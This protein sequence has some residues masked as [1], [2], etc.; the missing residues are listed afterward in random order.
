MGSGQDWSW[1]VWR[2]D[3]ALE[4]VDFNGAPVLSATDFQAISSGSMPFMLT[5]NGEAA[6]VIDRSGVRRLVSGQAILDVRMGG[7]I[8][9]TWDGTF[10]MGNTSGDSLNF[11]AAGTML[12][13]GRLIGNQTAYRLVVGGTAFERHT[14]TDERII[15]SLLGPAGATRPTGVIGTFQFT[16]RT[17]VTVNGGFGA[18]LVDSGG[19]LGKAR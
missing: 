12:S 17:A 13:T 4:S 11:D 3:G 8:T 16:H 14:I 5:G 9:P 15:G 1:G 7:S 19:A 2:V 18:D 10:T 6:A